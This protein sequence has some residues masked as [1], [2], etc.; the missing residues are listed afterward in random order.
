MNTSTSKPAVGIGFRPEALQDTIR[1]LQE[2]ETLEVMVDHYIA[3]GTP[4]RSQILDLSR[5]IPVVGHGVCLSIAT[6]VPPDERYLDQVAST[7]EA[8]RAPCH[9]EHLAFTKVPGR[10]LAQLLPVPRTYEVAEVIV[11]NLEVVRRHIAV[12]FGLENITYYYEYP[13]SEMS[14]LEFLKLIS[15]E[16]GTFLLLDLEN[17]YLNSCNHGFDPY[18]FIDGLPAGLV[19]AVHV[20]GGVQSPKLLLD[21]HDK[22]VPDPVFKLLAHLMTRQTPETIVLE[23]DDALDQFD[24]VLDDVRR[25]KDVV[26]RCPVAG[27]PYESAR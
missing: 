16:A 24:E 4:L 25:L 13:E 6:A 19:K 17:V 3:G 20:A 9:T 21:S 26:G 8:I 10:D 1:H 5:R 22:P 27:Q 18:A 2:F 23:R 15:R 11:R 14:E 12:P 7:L